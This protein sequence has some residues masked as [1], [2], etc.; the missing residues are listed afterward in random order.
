MLCPKCFGEAENVGNTHYICKNSR[1]GI[2]K[3]ED[4]THNGNITQFKLI[5][6]DEV[7]FPYNQIFVDSNKNRFYRKPYLEIDNST[8]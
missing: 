2:D 5:E 4:C 6:D 7:K 8:K 1:K 3:E